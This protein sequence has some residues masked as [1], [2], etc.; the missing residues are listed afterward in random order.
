MVDDK[1]KL[2]NPEGL[3]KPTGFS[4]AASAGGRLVALAGQ[5]GTDASGHFVSDD[6]VE[7]IAQALRNM[8]VALEAAGG[9]TENLI[10][11]TIFVRDV[12]SYKRRL[13]EIGRVYQEVFGR[14]YPPMTLV[15]VCRL[16]DPPAHVE[17][18]GWAV[19]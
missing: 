3:A 13:K 12:R 10:K 4:H 18:E 11:M 16:F 9:G 8:A 7:Q 14:H 19:V 5:V 17:I 1:V 6:L 15:E 2:I